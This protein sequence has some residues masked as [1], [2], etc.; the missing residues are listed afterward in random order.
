[1]LLAARILIIPYPDLG[2]RQDTVND[3]VDDTVGRNP[4][5]A[6]MKDVMDHLTGITLTEVEEVEE[7]EDML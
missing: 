1:M 2:S 7:N 5:G 6:T 3:S 4:E